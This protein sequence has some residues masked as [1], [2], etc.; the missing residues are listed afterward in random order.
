ML[1]SCNPLA[2]CLE[3]EQCY[4]RPTNI[5]YVH[6]EI[7]LRKNQSKR[8]VPVPDEPPN[9]ARF[10]ETF[11]NKRS[12]GRGYNGGGRGFRGGVGFRGRGSVNYGGRDKHVY[13]YCKMPGHFIKFCRTGIAKEGDRGIRKPNYG[14]YHHN[15]DVSSSQQYGTPPGGHHSK[16][17]WKTLEVGYKIQKNCMKPWAGS[18]A[19]GP[20][21]LNN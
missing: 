20:S 3:H 14:N 19:S 8:D 5:S 7:A 9:N 17:N 15:T 12:R 21:N 16:Q 18:S 6:A 11:A 1:Q 4:I 10:A 2:Y 13:H